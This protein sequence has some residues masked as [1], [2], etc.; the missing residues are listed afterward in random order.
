VFLI[1]LS[2][3]S[4]PGVL[5]FFFNGLKELTTRTLSFPFSFFCSDDA[6]RSN[7]HAVHTSKGIPPPPPS[8]PELFF[9]ALTLPPHGSADSITTSPRS[10]A[11]PVFLGD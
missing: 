10:H 5:T 6:L 9:F 2:Y 8:S 3:F 7:C 11:A 1:T 4:L